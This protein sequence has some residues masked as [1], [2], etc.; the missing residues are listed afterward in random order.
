MQK[1]KVAITLDTK[2]LGQ[3]DALVL[4]RRFPNRSQAIES[5]LADKLD[6]IAHRRLARECANLDRQEEQSSA[7][8]GLASD[9]ELWPEY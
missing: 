9:G 1:T 6:R 3:L 4:E 8:E 5:A 7:D 2:L